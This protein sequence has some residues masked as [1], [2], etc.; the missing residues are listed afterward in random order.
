MIYKLL[1]ECLRPIYLLFFFLFAQTSI[2]QIYE[3]H[4]GAGNT[5]GVTVTGSNNQENDSTLYSITGTQL[6]PDLIGASRFLAQATLG[7]S[8]EEIEHVST[9]GIEN[10]LDEQFNMSPQSFA[11]KHAEIFNETQELITNDFQAN[12]YM[13]YVFYDFVHNQPDALR[14]KVA[15]A[16]SQIFVISAYHG[17]N[18]G[19]NGPSNLMYYDFLYQGAFGNYKDM[20]TNVTFSVP[21]G[22]YLSHFMN[23][24]ADIVEKTYPDENFAR[25]IMQLFSIGLHMLNDD[26]TPKKDAYG[27]YIPTYDINNIA[28]L[29]NV[30][31]GLGGSATI[32]GAENTVFLQSWNIDKNAPMKM[33]DDYHSTVEKN[34]LPGVTLPAGQS[35]IEDLNQTLDILFNHPN[36][37]PFI[38]KRLIQHLVKSNP[39]P[40]YVRRITTIFNNNG[41]GVRGDLQ[42]VVKAILLDPEARDCS[43]IDVPVNGKLIQPL[44]RFTTLFKAFDLSTPSGKYWFNDYGTWYND[45]GQAFLASPSVFN[46]F[47]PFYAEDEFIAPLDL[48]SPEFQLLNSVTAIAYI[49]EMEWTIKTRP[50]NNETVANSNGTGLTRNLEDEPFF[51]FDDEI[52]IYDTQGISALLDRLDLILCRGQLSEGVKAIIANT[53]EQNEENL[54]SYESIDALEDA[55]YYV[56]MT[57]NYVIQK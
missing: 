22:N 51:N 32:D 48:V 6:K 54:S 38:G 15:F 9:V 4:I 56:M 19:G 10:W 47:S 3:D 27:D 8:Y 14:Q 12:K 33:F 18:L 46:F 7:A 42:A 37:G 28:E 53:I 50:F 35:G 45:V 21:M 24:R 55:L 44:E 25:E 26:G 34:I 16:L 49:N 17:S 39:S 5:V 23:Q 11:E 31:T 52:N 29:A 1:V 41:Q 13:S 43:W 20:L 2:A 57:P 36:V 40:S 30:F